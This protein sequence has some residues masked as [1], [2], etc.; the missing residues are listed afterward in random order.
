VT[1]SERDWVLQNGTEVAGVGIP[2][3]RRLFEIAVGRKTSLFPAPKLDPPPDQDTFTIGRKDDPIVGEPEETHLLKTLGVHE[4]TP[5][6]AAI[7]GRRATRRQ[8]RV[9]NENEPVDVENSDGTPGSKRRWK[10]LYSHRNLA[11]PELEVDL[12]LTSD[13]RPMPSPSIGNTRGEVKS[14]CE[15]TPDTGKF[16]ST[17]FHVTCRVVVT[18]RSRWLS[19]GGF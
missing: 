13:T 19:P 8:I 17:R 7:L 5:A 12:D 1:P 16:G 3:L 9:F 10:M 2:S 11:R 15:V 6:L 18:D 14:R 4:E